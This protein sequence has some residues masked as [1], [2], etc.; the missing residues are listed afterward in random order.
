MGEGAELAAEG[1]SVS[2]ERGGRFFGWYF[3]YQQ[4]LLAAAQG[5]F[6]TSR[7]LAGQII[8]WAGPRGARTPQVW[9]RHPLVL[10]D[11]G[12][13]DFESAYQHATAMSP[14][15]T[16]AWHVPHCLW[17]VMDLVEAAV[18]T[19]RQAEAERHVHAM[20]EADLAALS[21]RLSIL[22]AASAAI[23][24][25]DE[26]APALFERALSLPTVDQWPFDV[27]RVRL[28][29]GE[30]LRRTRVTTESR[31]HLQAALTAFQKL[32]AAPWAARAELELRAAGH[33]IKTPSSAPGA[34]A[35]TAQELQIA[36]LAA[37]GMTNK[38]IAER[39]FLSPRT[40]GGHLYQIFPKL[41]IT[42]RAALRDALAA[43]DSSLAPLRGTRAE[44]VI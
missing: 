32:G 44:R 30:R 21:P 3:R 9:A 41:G 2:E 19:R 6:D 25:E 31:I 42:T 11:L 10:A 43:V 4:A 8:G 33:A 16:L 12:E 40:V 20:Q 7:A 39:L 22:A 27:A 38:Q 1:L 28:A 36:R 37:S 35:L 23:A 13:G 15:G 14:A 5:R 29:Y 18:R 34:V 24:A 26:R 17:V